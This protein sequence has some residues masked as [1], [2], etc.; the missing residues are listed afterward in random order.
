MNNISEV[1]LFLCASLASKFRC[2]LT[3]H[4]RYHSEG[5]SQHRTAQGH[6]ESNVHSPQLWH[7]D[8]KPESWPNNSGSALT[9]FGDDFGM[10]LSIWNATFGFDHWNNYYCVTTKIHKPVRMNSWCNIPSSG[11]CII[12]V[13]KQHQYHQEH[14]GCAHIF[15]CVESGWLGVPS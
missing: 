9:M 14:Q 11:T 13:R 4:C 3:H 12:L 2:S 1:A 6:V 7:R 15:P 5:C 10:H 8:A